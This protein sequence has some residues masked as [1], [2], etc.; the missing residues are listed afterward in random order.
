M[1]V[2]LFI[3]DLDNTL[4]D[5]VSYF[6]PALYEM[7]EVASTTLN[8]PRER[9]LDELRAIHQ[10][11]GSTEH[12]FALLE[13][14]TVIERFPGA[15]FSQL[16]EHLRPAFEV[17]R[18]RREQN[19]RLYPSV[20]ETLQKICSLGT[21]ILAY[22]EAA[23]YNVAHRMRVLDLWTY[24]EGLYAPEGHAS[25]A[26][27]FG[28]TDPA[29]R[30]H[31]LPAGHRKPDPQ[32]LEAICQHAKVTAAE[33]L[34]VGDSITRDVAMGREAGVQVAW[35]KYGK[36][37]PGQWD[38]LVRVT[39]WTAA[40]IERENGLRIRYAD[41]RPDRC[42]NDFKDLLDHFEFAAPK[43]RSG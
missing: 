6:V 8:V 36:H 10:R 4:Y 25:V 24:I 1:P 7:V 26:R 42:L 13:T 16:K 27:D 38:K 11:Y 29:D 12:P 5:W 14:P 3:T 33:T 19:L 2:R 21:P 41:V 18:R 43:P 22:T 40:D 23:V 30:I 39:H 37:D 35:A 9:L 32:I 17:F 28:F 31:L 15:T 34:Y 20:A